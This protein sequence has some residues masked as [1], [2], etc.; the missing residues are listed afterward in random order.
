MSRMLVVLVVILGLVVGAR[1]S[2]NSSATGAQDRSEERLGAL[3]TKV[4]EQDARIRALEDRSE[5][6]GSA[7]MATEPATPP[8][9][10][11]ITGDYRLRQDMGGAFRLGESC[12]GYTVYRDIQEGTPITVKDGA[13]RH[14]GFGVLG[15]G[16]VVV[17][18][19]AATTNATHCLFP[20][21]I[22]RLPKT[23]RYVIQVGIRTKTTVTF[24]RLESEGWQVHL[25][26]GD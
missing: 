17:A 22:D 14:I 1:V 10:Y 18:D 4:A 7:A 24:G 25:A 19:T 21:E 13:G 3:E 23:D 20:L 12:T 9:V 15:P 5:G 26:L 8:P 2:I 6:P 16:V 11:T